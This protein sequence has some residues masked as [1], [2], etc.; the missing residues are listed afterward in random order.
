MSQLCG[1]LWQR[2]LGVPAIIYLRY[3]RPLCRF[4]K[5]FRIGSFGFPAVIILGHSLLIFLGLHLH[6]GVVIRA[7]DVLWDGAH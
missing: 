1:G 3:R 4:L 7:V 2:L 6:L 5:G